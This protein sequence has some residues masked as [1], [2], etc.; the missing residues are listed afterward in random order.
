MAAADPMVAAIPREMLVKAAGTRPTEVPMAQA[1][2]PRPTEVLAW[3]L[4]SQS[5]APAQLAARVAQLP[6]P[7]SSGFFAERISSPSYSPAQFCGPMPD[8]S[9][10]G[11][12]PVPSFPPELHNIMRPAIRQTGGSPVTDQNA[13]CGICSQAIREYIC[14]TVRIG[15]RM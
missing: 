9:I 14:V 7:S 5:A 2:P 12:A 3:L 1:V 10:G 6:M 4:A 15:S 8:R 13:P 11:A